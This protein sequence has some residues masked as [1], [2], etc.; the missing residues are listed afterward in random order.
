MAHWYNIYHSENYEAEIQVGPYDLWLQ[1]LEFGPTQADRVL[2]H[3]D[4]MEQAHERRF[5]VCQSS[6]DMSRFESDHSHRISRVIDHLHAHFTGHPSSEKAETTDYRDEVLIGLTKFPSQGS[7]SN[8]SQF[9]NYRSPLSSGS[10]YSDILCMSRQ[11]VQTTTQQSRFITPE[12]FAMEVDQD[13]DDVHSQEEL[14]LEILAAK[15]RLRDRLQGTA[16]QRKSVRYRRKDHPVVEG[17][18]KRARRV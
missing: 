5:A 1:Q 6:T 10:A 13:D 17:S 4:M 2:I 3:T 16:L 11:S 18:K 7:F 15:E 14:F 8:C 9:A 12:T